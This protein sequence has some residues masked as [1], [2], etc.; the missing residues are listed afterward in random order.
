MCE[1]K[2]IDLN[3]DTTK[4]ISDSFLYTLDTLNCG[5][6]F[7]ILLFRNPLG[8]QVD[9]SLNGIKIDLFKDVQNNLTSLLLP[10]GQLII[11]ITQLESNVTSFHMLVFGDT[12]N[13]SI[14]SSRNIQPDIGPW[15][16]SPLKAGDKGKYL[17][18]QG[19]SLTSPI[20]VGIEISVMGDCP[21]RLW[22]GYNEIN[23]ALLYGG[24]GTIC[25]RNFYR[26]VKPRFIFDRYLIVETDGTS[27][28]DCNV[29]V[30]TV[31]LNSTRH[32]NSAD[33]LTFPAWTVQSTDQ[34]FTYH[35]A[36]IMGPTW[37]NLNLMTPL[38]TGT[39]LTIDDQT[40]SG[41]R[42]VT[43][44]SFQTDSLYAI[45]EYSWKCS[46]GLSCDEG[47]LLR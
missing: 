24:I 44:C 34:S 25:G 18:Y 22:K 2:A 20:Q 45:V 41:K 37:I 15:T 11:Q 16:V 9:A 1:T 13:Y 39:T 30:H 6:N 3:G 47:P 35:L 19:S 8:Y 14:H 27:T 28:S 40:G 33:V 38:P 43:D 5:K 4:E 46:P 10:P 21:I 42:N 31:K 12:L 26:S 23:S 7:T 17:I 29:T 36:N 32:I